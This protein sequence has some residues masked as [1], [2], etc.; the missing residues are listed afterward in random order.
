MSISVKADRTLI[1]TGVKSHRFVRVELDAP[2]APSRQAAFST[3]R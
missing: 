2:E 3:R 1:P